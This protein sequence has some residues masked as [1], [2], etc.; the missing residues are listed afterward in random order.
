MIVKHLLKVIAFSALLFCSMQFA[1]AQN[2][3]VAGKV[4]DSKDGSVMSNASVNAKVHT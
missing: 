1:F 2:K 3:I 4:I